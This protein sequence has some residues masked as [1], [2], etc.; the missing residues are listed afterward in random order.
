MKRTSSIIVAGILAALLIVLVFVSTNSAD[1]RTGE[2]APVVQ[3]GD[4]LVPAVPGTFLTG[5]NEGEPLVIALNFIQANRA[6]LQMSEAEVSNLVV[7]DNYLSQKT[8]TTHI[9]LVQTHNGIEVYN[10][11]LNIN[12][13]R[14]GSVI[15]VGNRVVPNL[16]AA[17]QETEIQLS[18][19][20]AVE[21]AAEHLRLELNQTP[22]VEEVIGGAAQAVVIGDS[23]ISQDPIPAKLVYQPLA[24]GTVRLAWDLT[25]YELSGDNWWQIRIDAA[26]GQAL[27]KN[28]LVVHDNW[29]S[30][31]GH[32]GA[33]AQDS[34]LN[35]PLA[36]SAVPSS[37][38]VYAMPVESPNYAVPA[39]PADARTF[40]ISPWLDAPTASPMGWH[41]NTTTSWTN[42]Q[43]NNVDSH[44][45]AIR[46]DCGATLECDPPLDLTMEPTIPT[47]VDAA[48]VNLFYWNNI[49]H[50]LTYE[51]GFDEAAGNFQNDNFGLG[52]LG[53]DRVNAN[54]QA[55]GNCNA[56]FGTPP[57]GSQPT[58]NMFNC[59][60]ASPARDGDL[61]NGVI[62]HEYGHGL[63][64]RLTGGPGNVSCLNNS[65]QM[66]EGWSDWLGLI[67]TIEP[68]DA[69]TDTRPIGTW[70]LGTGPDGPGVR[71]TP[72]STDLSVNP[73]TYGDIGGLAIPHGVGYAW[74]GMVW[75]VVWNLIDEYG[76]NPD[77]YADWSTGGN[78][79]AIQLIIDGMK[80]QPCSPGFVDG[81]DAIL[82]ADMAL[83]GGV[84]QCMIWEG[85][86]KRGLGF[87]ADQ[88]SSGS[89]TDG[90]EAF[91]IPNFCE[92]LGVVPES[93]DICVGDV[94][95]YEVTLGNAFNAPVT[96]TAD[97]H[98]AG[99]TAT[100]APN[101]VPTV[102]NTTT[103]TIGNTAG[104]A[105]GA[106]TVTITGTDSTLTTSNFL[107]G[108]NV[109]DAAP[110]TVSLTS[111][112]DTAT[113]VAR[114]PTFEWTAATQGATYLLEVDDNSDFSSLVYSA[115]VEG[116]T[117][118]AAVSL[119][120]VTTYYWR[121]T[122]MNS[123]GTGTTSSVFS[124]TTE[125]IP[126]ILLVDDD[127]NGPNVQATY[128]AALDAL[129]AEYD[130]WDTNNS[131]NEPDFGFMSAY[132]AIVWFTGD[133][134]GGFAGPSAVSEAELGDF[135]DSG[136][137]LFLI[138][139]DYH[140][141]RGTTPF[142]TNYLGA[143]SIL[144][145]T[146]NYSS[147]TGMNSVFGGLG[148]Y[149]LTY[150]FTDF[151]DIVPPGGTAELAF[152][153]NNGND[154][155][156][157]KDSG[158]Y[159][160]AFFGYP[161]EAINTASG[162]EEVMET[163]LNWCGVLGPI[164]T[165]D[166]TVID[167]SDSQP[168]NGALITAD[169]G[170][171]AHSTTTNSSGNYEMSL[172]PGTYDILVTAS[173]YFSATATGVTIITDTVTTEDFAL[174]PAVGTLERDHDLIEDTVTMGES[175]T[176]TL[177]VSNT[178]TVAFD[179]TAAAGEAWADVSPTGGTLN[180][181]ESIVLSVIFDSNATAGAGTYSTTLTFSGD[182]DNSP[183]PVDLVLHVLQGQFDL[184]MPAIRC[185][186]C[187]AAA[188][189]T[190]SL[191]WFVPLMGLTAVAGL[192]I[193]KRSWLS[194][195]RDND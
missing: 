79:L 107:V 115:T 3:Q 162:R 188:T 103:L 147:V 33:S 132:K 31:Q 64:N 169:D 52:G 4:G 12:I 1:A 2:A 193:K 44:K 154:A 71:P 15:N 60:I 144:D 83:T 187:T 155:A 167:D 102:P 34:S 130:I 180:P 97:G 80:V 150:P 73:T 88:G 152:D 42:T 136:N 148:P 57:D 54:A 158:V 10:S 117:H 49:I 89:T 5:P 93:L 17:I 55:P 109:F 159:K 84:N 135:L 190:A 91:D 95:E 75:E 192:G 63:S 25:I 35:V 23:G 100:F 170:N 137:C 161:W 181:G 87:S 126:P 105:A 20:N 118:M 184:Y 76:Y 194:S 48:T 22:A 176:H 70:L 160:T 124:F 129:G 39:P 86:A 9:Y 92:F 112:P 111:P 29:G 182:F 51:Y 18:A 122:A 56:N 168:I 173:G 127:D 37:Y 85:F 177:T 36:A 47:N 21:N 191:P 114:Q 8:G 110:G 40:E 26:T 61:D 68:G 186:D 131:D 62:A 78:N 16:T 106:Y 164:G 149:N 174:T 171:E 41:S 141:D 77:F 166:G 28:N 165:L 151:A 185:D 38:L 142:M 108:L 67:M 156:I 143:G 101:P 179:F 53:N 116:T 24:D 99:T 104:A 94:A 153:G 172:P 139:Q 121:V 189:P 145:D 58:M 120:S 74:A 175:V 72:Y 146:G 113:D 195:L 123:C 66:G 65:E 30:H 134:F 128:T 13:A 46:F 163:A 7:Q 27:D 119:A 11:V 140:F 138:S 19:V 81:R 183:D 157:N 50:D 82:A 43:G 14:D 96:M 178:G 45:G 125:E 59:D 6:E 98:P 32:G 69:G 133:E 90:T